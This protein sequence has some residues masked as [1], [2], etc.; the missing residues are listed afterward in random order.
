MSGPEEEKEGPYPS[1][2]GVVVVMVVLTK[3]VIRTQ[4][5]E[6]GRRGGGVDSGGQPFPPHRSLP[7]SGGK[8]GEGDCWPAAAVAAA[9]V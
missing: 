5:H 6:R 2:G 1:S 8:D 9:A 4:I 3:P 7:H